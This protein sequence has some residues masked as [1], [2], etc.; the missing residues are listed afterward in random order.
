M[1]ALQK[2]SAKHEKTLVSNTKLNTSKIGGNVL[3]SKKL[4]SAQYNDQSTLDLQPACVFCVVQI[5]GI[6]SLIMGTIRCAQRKSASPIMLLTPVAPPTGGKSHP[7]REGTMRLP[8][9][10]CHTIAVPGC[11]AADACP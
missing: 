2:N 1:V 6:P 9:H 10:R 5:G 8:H 4:V 3:L 11:P 7:R